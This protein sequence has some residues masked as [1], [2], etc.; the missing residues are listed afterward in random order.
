MLKIKP[1]SK[2]YFSEVAIAQSSI[3]MITKI[4]VYL[5][6]FLLISSCER[7]I[8]NNKKDIVKKSDSFQFKPEIKYAKGFSINVTD[9]KKQVAI[10]NPETHEPEITITFLNDHS[11]TT[12]GENE[13]VFD[14]N[15]NSIIPLS[16]SF[17]SMIDALGETDKIIA[18][19]NS[20][21]IF[22]HKIMNKVI[23]GDIAEV[24]TGT[25]INTEKI[26]HLYPDLLLLNSTPNTNVQVKKLKDAGINI[27]TNYD[28]Y[29]KNGLA[30]AEWIKFF[31]ALFNK[32]SLADAIFNDIEKKY[33]ELKA[34]TKNITDSTSVVFSSDYGGTWY[35]PG[36]KSYVAQFLSDAAGTYSWKNDNSMASLPLSIEVVVSKTLDAD[37]WINPN[38]Y[39]L[40]NLSSQNTVYSEFKAFKNKQVYTSD[41]RMTKQGGNDYY[42]NGSLHPEWIL[43]DYIKMLHPELMKDSGFVFFRKLE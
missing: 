9:H 12:L 6:A 42:E 26:I 13:I 36:G 16:S 43:Q 15:I 17:F 23:K 30:K 28:W 38:A 8:S 5:F 20:S 18:I 31:G 11:E 34:L 21:F 4:G 7:N 19:E 32:D 10:Y 24:G 22:N 40:N 37:V 3:F 27:A 33:L 39:N 35:I 41:L 1:I 29:E 14:N 25:E 2:K